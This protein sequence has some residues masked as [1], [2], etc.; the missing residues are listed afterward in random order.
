MTHRNRHSTEKCSSKYGRKNKMEIKEKIIDSPNEY[1]RA[2]NAEDCE[3]V[4]G[5]TLLKYNHLSLALGE[6][7]PFLAKVAPFANYAVCALVL[8]LVLGIA[9]PSC[10]KKGGSAGKSQTT[11]L[12]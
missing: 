2:F 7:I 10:S 1:Y 4:Q 6:K 5:E 9:V 12:A 8:V 11:A 3:D